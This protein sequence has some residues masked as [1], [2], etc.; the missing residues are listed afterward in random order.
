MGDLIEGLGAAAA[1]LAFAGAALTVPAASAV[2]RLARRPPPPGG[3]ALAASVLKP[4]HGAAP[5]LSANLAS[6]LAQEHAAP[7]EVLFAVRDPAD[8]AA[9]AAEAA[10]AA[11]PGVP[12]RLV[13]D[14]RL[15]GSNRKVSQLLNLEGLARHPVL[16]VADADMRVEA[17]WLSR[18]T[19]PLVDP[20][21]GLVTCL[22]RAEP[23]D[24]RFWSR[25]A[26]LGTDWHFL[27]NAALGEAMGQAQGCYG[28][29]MALRREVLDRIGGFAPS[30][31]CW[32]T[33]TRWGR[34][35]A[36]WACAWWRRGPCRWTHGAR[37]GA[38]R[39]TLA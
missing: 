13:R 19:A 39:S 4:L 15:H 21:V 36:A 18:A 5:G 6:T 37:G 14:P 2:R 11:H 35:C 16:V 12:A 10:M 20:D 25:L 22:Y 1:A 33:T 9:A 26:A 3:P 31:T 7:F 38:A 32:R 24:G 30:P 27:P 29:T 34:P 28:A 17:D 8:P 23:A